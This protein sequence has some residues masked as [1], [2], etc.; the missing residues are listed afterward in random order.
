MTRGALKEIIPGKLYQRGQIY[1]MHRYLK[2]HLLEDNNITV[3]VNLWSKMDSDLA[4]DYDA[5]LYI[6]SPMRGD[7]DLL[8][9]RMMSLSQ[10]VADLI[11]QGETVLVLCEAGRTR[12]V[13]FCA[14]VLL[15][16][17]W[18]GKDALEMVKEA[19]GKTTL[20]PSMIRFLEQHTVEAL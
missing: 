1:T 6:H 2:K 13:F 5:P 7:A 9:N 11:H 18:D 8:G 10:F 20:R 15:E 3:V 12:S 14:L 19:C 17:G 4:E 16:Q